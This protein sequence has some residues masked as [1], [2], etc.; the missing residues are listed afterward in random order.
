M[1]SGAALDADG[2]AFY[3]LYHLDPDVGR[4][5]QRFL[6]WAAELHDALEQVADAEDPIEVLFGLD[7]RRL[8]FMLEGLLRTYRRR[9]GKPIKKRLQAVKALEDQL[10]AVD[11]AQAMLDAG[12]EAQVPKKAVRYLEKS[13]RK[14]RKELLRMLEDGWVPDANGRVPGIA[15]LVR[16]LKHITWESREEDLATL[17]GALARRL[18]KVAAAEYDMRDLEEGIHELR[19]QLRWLPICL[20]ALDGVARLDDDLNPVAEYA[21]LLRDPLAQS[22]FAQLPASGAEPDPFPLSRSLFVANTKLIGDL[23]DLKDDLQVIQA[24]TRACKES[25]VARKSKEARAMALHHLGKAPEDVARTYRKKVQANA[26]RLSK[27]R[28]PSR[29]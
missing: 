16:T 7:V 14:S 20:T 13:L 15:K 21:P 28:G 25:G 6:A 24:L 4:P 22:L 17:R 1:A 10:G 19:R 2:S 5:R 23:G 12:R 8:T 29:S 26:R 3:A 27:R 11:Y 18:E 9:Y